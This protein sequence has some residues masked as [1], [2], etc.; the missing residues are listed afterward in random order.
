M[1]KVDP[2]AT[3]C[4]AILCQHTELSSVVLQLG[5]DSAW[6]FSSFFD[7]LAYIDGKAQLDIEKVKGLL[8]LKQG[9]SHPTQVM[10]L[11]FVEAWAVQVSDMLGSTGWWRSFSPSFSPWL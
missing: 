8:S 11:R 7:G 2:P 3:Q 6:D 10:L 5:F 1:L 4:S 9:L